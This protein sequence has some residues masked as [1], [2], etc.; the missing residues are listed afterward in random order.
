MANENEDVFD[1]EIR[2]S[3]V[4]DEAALKIAENLNEELKTLSDGVNV[5]V[6]MDFDEDDIQARIDRLSAPDIT[7]SLDVDTAAAEGELATFDSSVPDVTAE[8]E[9]DT[10][11]AESELST[12]G[13]ESAEVT[14]TAELDDST[15]QTE[16]SNLDSS[17]PT[18]EATA[19]LDDSG[20]QEELKTLDDA[21]V[22]PEIDARETKEGK[23]AVDALNRL[24]VLQTIQL[25]I[26]V[27]G[28][29]LD[30][31]KS[32]ADFAINPFLSLD[33]AVAE[34]SAKTGVAGDE[35]NTV[36]GIIETLHQDDLG[37]NIGQITDVAIAAKQ[38]GLDIDTAARAALTFTHTFDNQDPIA[39]MNT[40]SQMVEQGLAPNLATAGD[41]LTVAFQNGANKGG[42]LLATLNSNAVA[43]H[44]MGL[45][46]EQ[47]LSAINSLIAGGIPTANEAA[48]ALTSLDKSLGEAATNPTS[49]TSQLLRR[50]GIDNPKEDGKAIGADYLAGLIEAIQ[51]APP[52]I[53]EQATSAL[54]GK[55]GTKNT[56]ALLKLDVS[57]DSFENAAGASEAAA[58]AAD[59]SLS[60]AVDDFKLTLETIATNFLSSDQIKLPEKLKAIKEGLQ[61]A[62]DVL[63]NG[64]T[65]E[66]AIKVTLSSIGL[67]D[68]FERLE[69]S[70]GDFVIG[71]EQAVASVLETFGHGKEAAGI[72]AQVAQQGQTQLAFNLKTADTEQVTDEIAKAVSRGVTAEGIT[73]AVGT[74]VSELV[75][76]GATEQAQKIVDATKEG[77]SIHFAAN[78][79]VAKMLL[80]GQGLD[81][82]FTL[83]ITP[84]M[85]PEAVEQLKQDT[86]D[87]FNASGISLD[88]N[89][90]PSVSQTDIDALQKQI[91]DAN[92]YAAMNAKKTTVT[93]GPGLASQTPTN[94]LAIA[95]D[96]DALTAAQQRRQ[97]SAEEA[98]I[99]L[100][101]HIAKQDELRTAMD[102]TLPTIDTM[103]ANTS[104]LATVT[105]DAAESANLQAAANSE[106]G[107]SMSQSLADYQAL[108]AQYKAGIITLDQFNASFETMMNTIQSAAATAGNV[109]TSTTNV[110][111]N[112]TNNIASGA[113]GTA[114]GTVTADEVKGFGGG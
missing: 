52:D 43:F 101:D 26:T 28:N 67:D 18:I 6:E 23:D 42:D 71:V 107:Q 113:Q 57:D 85:S 83:P 61:E 103:N 97:T 75:A 111:L 98:T 76:N 3:S 14:V 90:V 54:F 96:T 73:S 30:F 12:F 68:D 1:I 100:S 45:N 44:D 70:I 58:S 93:S 74:A 10:A 53:Q 41:L 21:K 64:G 24:S 13:D 80:E 50:L 63:L 5:P 79:P 9:V 114:V 32:V 27:V 69:A 47:A 15:V 16:L 81:T 66:S 59:D 20:A 49:D 39:V 2:Y 11:T 109:S 65:F 56:S 25:G 92:T 91:D 7:A 77:G 48:L 19:T 87:K 22:T 112:Q 82:E 36:H 108:E 72:R 106:L 55:Q 84:D 60:G 88:A 95:D 35:L 51:N 102:T 31:V 38:A 86:I 94:Q 40:L 4:G 89:V 34:F 78:D 17:A 62:S 33:D 46:G 105:A 8:L 104:E 29:A 110:T 99:S 37:E